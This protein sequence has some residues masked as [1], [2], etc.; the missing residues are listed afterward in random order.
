VA[1]E[2]EL[3]RKAFAQRAWAEAYERLSQ[4][5]A[6]TLSADDLLQLATSA[7]MLGRMDDFLE[8]TERTHH[9][10]LD[11]AELLAATRCAVY[12]G[13][14]LA[15]RGDLAH[16]SGWFARAQ[17]LVE[18]H[19]D[20][21]AERG[22][23]LLPAAM[24]QLEMGQY[25]EAASNAAAAVECGE[26]F[27]DP[28]LLAL[29]LHVQGQTLIKQARIDEG[30][31]RLDEAML[32]VTADDVSPIISG[33]V[34]CGVIAGCEDAYDLRR[35]R[36]WTEA[37]TR[38]CEQQPELVSFTG[39]CLAHRAGI[40]Q[41]RGAWA[42]ALEEAR[43]ARERC[44]EAMNEP[45]AGQALY[46]QGELHRLQGDFA[47]AEAAYRDA[48]RYGHEPQPGLSLLRLGQGDD[49]AAASTIRRALSETAEPLQRTRLLPAQA[50]IALAVGDVAEA[51][52]AA[53]ELSSIAGDFEILMLRAIAAHT[54]GMVALAEEEPQSALVSLRAAR[55]T[56]QELDAP[57]E[58]AR[59]RVLIGLACRMLGDEDTAALELDNATTAF[60]QLGALPDLARVEAIVRPD[61][62][63]THGLT[64]R[65]LEVLRLVAAGK[66]NRE[67]AGELVVSEHTVARHVQ[68]I[69]SKLAVSSRSA[70]TAFA[71]E[72]GLV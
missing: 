67:I 18:R 66:T 2:I 46:Y 27:R 24:Q 7:Y 14:N 38:W 8:L 33:V 72:H 16:A 28:D 10:Y 58:T 41:L 12:L 31:R 48:S 37:L 17:R 65:E 25:D 29:A 59:T 30:L 61:T 52:R 32:G 44:E 39:R 11:A 36:E 56:W 26:R 13:I 6:E 49:D 20:D 21:C 34:Y 19:G 40:M 3:G 15:I 4:A 23:L 51:R 42:E 45:A 5:E 63:E 62:R 53:D 71:F 70:A 69:F 55:A 1:G 50:E 22:Y 47:A 43:R 60:E 35:A 54:Q 57:Y 68:N 64:P 9:A